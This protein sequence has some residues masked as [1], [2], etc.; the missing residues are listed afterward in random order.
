MEDK[1]QEKILVVDD[2][3]SLRLICE[4]ALLDEGYK[5][6]TVEDGEKALQILREQKDIDL[7]ISDLKMPN[8]NGIELIKQAKKEELDADFLIMTGFGTIEVAVECIRLGAADYLPKP[9]NLSHLIVKVRKV[10][11]ERKRRLERRRLSSVV[12]ILN[13]SSALNRIKDFKGILYEFI[14]HLQKNFNP[15]S[16]IISFYNSRNGRLEQKVIKG[17]FFKKN[18]QL[19]FPLNK[20]MLDVLQKNSSFVSDNYTFEN[21]EK[22]FSLLIIPL[23]VQNEKI[24]VLLLLKENKEKI[25]SLL[26]NKKLINIFCMHAAISLQNASFFKRLRNLNLEII[27]SYAKA[28]EARDYYTKGH[29]ENVARYAFN[30]G[31]FIGLGDKELELLY[32]GGMLHDIGK[33]GISDQILNK[34]GKLT[35]EEYEKMKQHPV[36]GKE[37]LSK[38]EFLKEVVPLVY[39]HHERIDGKGYP[40]GLTGEQIPLLVKILSVVDAFEAMTSNRSYRNALP[41]EEV[42]KIM[43]EGAGTQWDEDLVHKWFFLVKDRGMEELK[44]ISEFK[45]IFRLLN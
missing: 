44:N 39:Y 27:S 10:L 31:K 11:Q 42:E 19:I 40:E 33:I 13:L 21:I 15:D 37:I 45:G 36:I 34:P 24:G 6:F 23:T 5:V 17:K 12:R 30:L 3:E 25:S 2:E 16:L 14:Y 8:L 43:F 9:F 4:D 28:V 29:S 18:Y 38:I 22:K 20:K 7:V 32:V 41:L 35:D 26:K 1:E